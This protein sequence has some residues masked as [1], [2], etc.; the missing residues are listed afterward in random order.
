[1]TIKS[2]QKQKTMYSLPHNKWTWDQIED[3][4][5]CLLGYETNDK[6]SQLAAN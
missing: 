4:R 3:G 2:L 5:L 6:T 1:M